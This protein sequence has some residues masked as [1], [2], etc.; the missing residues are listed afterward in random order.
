MKKITSAA[1]IAI[2]SSGTCLAEESIIG[3]WN[4]NMTSEYGDF[5]FNLTL[6]EGKT[7]KKETN[8]FGTINTDIGTWKTDGN[9]LVM[10]RTKYIKD[11]KEKESSQEF[12]RTIVSN[13]STNLELKHANVKT[14][15]SKVNQ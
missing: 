12:Q 1:L 5:T 13:T 11:G 8:M 3:K 15:C 2:V 6:D 10:K 14:S 9:A 4:C 7:Y